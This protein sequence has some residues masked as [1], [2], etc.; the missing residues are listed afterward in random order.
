MCS[1]WQATKPILILFSTTSTRNDLNDRGFPPEILYYDQSATVNAST[2]TS[3]S[4]SSEFVRVG[5][6]DFQG[7]VVLHARSRP[8]QKAI[9]EDIV[10][11][12][13]SL[14]E[15][16][17][18]IKAL[19]EANEQT[20]GRRGL[21]SDEIYNVVRAFFND[22]IKQAV[23]YAIEDL[24][25][26]QI[27]PSSQGSQLVNNS[28]QLFASAK[29]AVLGYAADVEGLSTDR[30][31]D[32]LKNLKGQEEGFL[33]QDEE[34]DQLV[35]GSLDAIKSTIRAAGVAALRNI[36]QLRTSFNGTNIAD[37]TFDDEGPMFAD[38]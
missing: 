30:I 1:A 33:L 31:K 7:R 11:N 36:A 16:K 14:Q 26:T 4:E 15:L 5:S 8:L 35:S 27:N 19:A 10:L 37:T 34:V 13:Q 23:K 9:T 21:T 38:W 3:E 17:Y 20:I 22:K 18:K 2:S 12:L 29:S 28:K 32:K 6:L 25:A 24:A